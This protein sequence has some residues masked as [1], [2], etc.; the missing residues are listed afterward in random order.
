VKIKAIFPNLALL[1]FFAAA[2][3]AANNPILLVG[4]AADKFSFYSS[5]ILLAEGFNAFDTADLSTINAK[6]LSGYDMV[7]LGH[8]PLTRRQADLFTAWVN[9]GGNLIAM[10]PD[11]QLAS[12][13]GIRRTGGALMNGYLRIDTSSAPGNGIVGDPIQFH[14]AADLYV[15]SGASVVATL[16][17][18]A[19]DAIPSPAVTLRR[20]IGRGGGA[21]AFTYDLARSIVYT[22]QGNPAWA[23]QARIGQGGP[24][25]SA[26]MFFGK[27]K[28]DS[29]RDW[30][31]LNNI[32]IPQADEQQRLL[33]NLILNLNASHKPLPRFWY[34]PFSK[35][36]VVVMTGDDHGRGATAGRF[37][38]FIASSPAGCVVANW[39]C[40]RATSYIFPSTPITA[41]QVDKY[42]S[43]GFEVA[44]HL[45]SNCSNW[46]PESL[47]SAASLQ[48]SQL[49]RK[50]PANPAPVTNRTHC[51]AWSDWTSQAEVELKHGIRLDTTYY[52][53]PQS[54]V[55]R[56]PGLFTGSGMPMRFARTDG[57]AVDV[58]QAATQMTDESGEAFPEFINRLL[59]NAV[60]PRGFYG[61][62]TANM[63]T[64]FNGGAYPKLYDL[65]RRCEGVW[66]KSQL[67][68]DQIVTASRKRGVP[69][70]SAKQ[71]LTW[72]DGRNS[73]SFGS[74]SWSANTL[75]FKVTAAPL[76]IGLQA[77]LPMAS[78]DARLSTVL[79][80]GAPVSYASEKIKGVWYS[81]FP[82]LSGTYSVMYTN[83]HSTANAKP[84]SGRSAP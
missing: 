74:M 44:L 72:L 41:A 6:T 80:D 79:H 13:L 38:D 36:A 3:S 58:Y 18:T 4:S 27:A 71:L 55:V 64:D 23:G 73:S 68:A 14:D 53:W 63:H 30:V 35:K 43:Q 25:R 37:E 49:A 9:T 47:D 33:A 10:R 57:T 19:T 24:I 54:W 17:S 56:T 50:L 84:A 29:Q 76:A 34:F 52:Y 51:I 15:P 39:E 8:V 70:V 46:T 40:V 65:L 42:T 26:D 7:I 1:L 81:V 67:W 21:A 66:C 48:L 83:V 16:Y 22:R 12:L 62:F 61:A 82:A 31:D 20:G 5:E 59:D 77:M 32:A 78:G 2:S 75:S 11:P 60:G 28:S 69:V 45:S